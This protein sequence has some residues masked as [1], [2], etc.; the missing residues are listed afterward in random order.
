[1]YKNDKQILSKTQRKTLKKKHPKD[2]KILPKKKK[3]KGILRIFR[4]KKSK[5]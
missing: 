4:R 1:M 3:K 5:S 2:I